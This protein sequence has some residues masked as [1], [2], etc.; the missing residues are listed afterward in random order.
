MTIDLHAHSTASDGTESP[1]DLVAAAKAAGLT[2]LAITDHDTTAGWDEAAEAAIHEG[3]ELVRGI[4][5]SCSRS[6][7]SIHLLAYLPNPDDPR[8][9]IE[10][11]RARDS[12]VSRM[13]RMIERMVEDGIPITVAEVR[14][15]VAPGA[16][17]GRPHLADALVANG[18]VPSRDEA[19]RDLLHDGSKYYVGH[20]APDPVTAIKLVRA[21]GGVPVLAHPFA[22][23]TATVTDAM[24]EEW[25]A[26]GLAGLEARHRDHEPADVERALRL[27][28]RHDLVVTGSS[29]YHGT[30]K[31]N[32]LGEFTT[33]P[34]QWARILEQSHGVKV[35]GP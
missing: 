30:G 20:Y 4:E 9:A 21:A 10:L 17:L 1:A 18:V 33:A 25:A 26:A 23:R 16:T 14:A 35:V 31:L 11:A 19:F 15:H 8:L 29:D 12:R 6:H 24:V 5:I 3:I 13:D 2:M 27:A 22:M 7:R 34:R 28:E 32:R